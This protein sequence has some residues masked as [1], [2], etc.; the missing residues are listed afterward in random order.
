MLYV[1]SFKEELG[2]DIR[3]FEINKILIFILIVFGNLKD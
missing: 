2:L 1:Y 3:F